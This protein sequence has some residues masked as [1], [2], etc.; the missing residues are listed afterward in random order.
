MKKLLKGSIFSFILAGFI[1]GSVS[2]ASAE[3]TESTVEKSEEEI[4]SVQSD[5]GGGG[6][7]TPTSISTNKVDPGGG[8]W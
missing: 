8:G 6:W 1:F 2:F 7:I 5:P 4:I 3:E